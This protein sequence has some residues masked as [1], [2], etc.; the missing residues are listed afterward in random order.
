[1]QKVP[2]RFD[3]SLV[4]F[5]GWEM[6]LFSIPSLINHRNFQVVD[7]IFYFFFCEDDSAKPNISSAALAEFWPVSC[8]SKV[9][10][11]KATGKE[12]GLGGFLK[13]FTFLLLQ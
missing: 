9:Y 10:L 12:A 11:L 8:I 13:N 1:M 3:G 5:T 7:S 2:K 6:S 4:A